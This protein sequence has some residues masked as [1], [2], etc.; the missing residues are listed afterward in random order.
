MNWARRSQC[1]VCNTP[2]FSKAEKRTG[3]FL[4]F[5]CFCGLNNILCLIIYCLFDEMLYF[6]HKSL[7]PLNVGSLV[8]STFV[9]G[10]DHS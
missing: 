7:I 8:T 1:N 3:L 10:D 4:D 9:S 2:K 6:H 5:F